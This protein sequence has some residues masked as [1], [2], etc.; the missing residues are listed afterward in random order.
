MWY[1]DVWLVFS[2]I[3]YQWETYVNKVPWCNM[4]YAVMPIYM[5]YWE[6]THFMSN[7]SAWRKSGSRWSWNRFLRISRH[8][9]RTWHW[10]FTQQHTKNIGEMSQD[11]SIYRLSSLPTYLSY[12]ETFTAHENIPLKICILFPNTEVWMLPLDYFL[13]GCPVLKLS[14]PSPLLC[15]SGL[16]VP[17]PHPSDSRVGR[18]RPWSSNQF[19]FCYLFYGLIFSTTHFLF[20]PQL[21]NQ[22]R[23]P[24]DDFLD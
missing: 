4:L 13:C 18:E 2:L 7:Y 20:S 12:L 8:S 23:A 21:I 3:S 24:K 9:Q 11:L 15:G 22:D 14:K 6:T 1:K 5:K 16:D 10:H 17:V 19:F